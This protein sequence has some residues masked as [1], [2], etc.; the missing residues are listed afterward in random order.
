VKAWL[1]RVAFYVGTI[2]KS[3]NVT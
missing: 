3:V 2:Q 1:K